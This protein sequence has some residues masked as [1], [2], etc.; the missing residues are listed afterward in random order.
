MKR[1]RALAGTPKVEPT[2]GR[3]P[4]EALEFF[5]KKGL[6][7]GFS[8][9]DVW[10]EEH[11]IAFTIAKVMELDILADVQESLIK[12]LK[13][14]IPFE[15]WKRDILPTLDKSGWT[16]FN[17]DR[18]KPRRLRIIYDTNMRMAR[19][20]GQ[21]ERI[22]RTKKTRPFLSYEAGPAVK[23]RDE[24]IPWFGVVLPVDDP[25]WDTAMPVN[26]YG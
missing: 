26:G 22:Q 10:K 2:A 1:K 12:S 24:H 14:G 6:K 18:P 21:W 15:E 25:F 20:T 13:E 9:E 5:E 8:F 23:H 16:Q 7:P 3:P 19:S 4:K 11:N 17:K